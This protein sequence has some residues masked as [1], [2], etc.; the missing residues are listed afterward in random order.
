MATVSGET[1]TADAAAG[2]AHLQDVLTQVNQILG[3]QNIT[4]GDIEY[5]DLASAAFNDISQ[6][7]EG[8]LFQQS[9]AA[10]KTR[11]NLFLVNKVWSGTLLGYSGSIDGAK[12]KGS[13]VTGVV[14]IYFDAQAGAIA[15]VVAHEMLHY[16]GLWH[17]VEED[18]THDVIDDTPNCPAT[19]TDAN[20][21]TEEGGGLLMHWQ[22]NGGKT[23]TD[24]Q[25]K[26]AR[27]HPLLHHPAGGAEALRAAPQPWVP[28][29]ETLE[30]FRTAPVGWC[31]T[32]R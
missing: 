13:E 28:D 11:L 29:A 9:S 22:G 26:V 31:G 18:G 19:G 30:F 14:S 21:P 25:G 3:A 32:R 10:S 20:C 2:T 15:A 6:G 16:L 7:E 8:E 17:T 27:G 24:G 12:K 4:L 23:F 5:Y 1:S